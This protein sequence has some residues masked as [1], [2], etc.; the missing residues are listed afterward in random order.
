MKALEQL[1][2]EH[3]ELF[4]DGKDGIS[5]KCPVEYGYFPHKVCMTDYITCEACWNVN[6]VDEECYK[7]QSAS[8]KPAECDNN[9]LSRRCPYDTGNFGVYQCLNEHT[10]CEECLK[11]NG[12]N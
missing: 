11:E 8:T 5:G 4:K 3:P 9:E 6:E 10:S 1:K 12:Q 7:K 2:L